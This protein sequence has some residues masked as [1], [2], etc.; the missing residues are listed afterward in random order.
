LDDPSGE[1]LLEITKEIELA[2]LIPSA[3][4]HLGWMG[5]VYYVVHT[6]LSQIL[7]H[8]AILL[9]AAEFIILFRAI[10]YEPDE[11]QHDFVSSGLHCLELY[12]AFIYLVYCMD[13]IYRFVSAL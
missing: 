13:N 9:F 5:F 2:S 6:S 4:I 1:E 8:G 12:F 10:R 3:I 11:A 7:F